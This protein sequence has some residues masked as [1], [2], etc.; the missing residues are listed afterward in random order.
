MH[1]TAASRSFKKLFYKNSIKL[2]KQR[3]AP[4]KK[5][6]Y[7]KA[8]RRECEIK[9]KFDHEQRALVAAMED[10]DR[11]HQ[12]ASQAQKETIIH[13]NSQLDIEKTRFTTQL[14]KSETER[15]QLKAVVAQLAVPKDPLNSLQKSMDDQKRSYDV[16][17]QKLQQLSNNDAEAKAVDLEKDVQA[18]NEEIQQ[19]KETIHH[20]CEERNELLA[21]ID[22]LK[23]S[24]LGQGTDVNALKSQHI[25]TIRSEVADAF[26]TMAQHA[27]RKK[28]QKLRASA[29][30]K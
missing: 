12:Q 1:T 24:H 17:I 16:K 26:E 18:R 30:Q 14:Q 11:V 25:D 6:L 20:E 21:L 7:I 15:H 3:F 28:Q 22:R 4:F 27:S 8:D 23:S 9:S 10:A 19:L 13:L 29:R 5:Y 2:G